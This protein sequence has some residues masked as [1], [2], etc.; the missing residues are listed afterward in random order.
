MDPATGIALASSAIKIGSSIFGNRSKK[1]AAK[2]NYKYQLALQK[3][4]Q[5]W[6]TEMSNTAHQREV[7]DLKAAGLNP[8]LSAGGSGADTGTPGG[9]TTQNADV[10]SPEM[11]ILDAVS[12]AKSIETMDKN[13]EQIDANIRNQTEQTY[14]DTELKKAETAKAMADAGLS[15]KQ[16]EYYLKH[17]VFPGATRT[18][19]MSW[20]GPGGIGGSESTTTPIGYMD[21]PSDPSSAKALERMS[22]EKWKSLS[23]AQ[24]KMFPKDIR[25]LYDRTYN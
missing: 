5:E 21:K 22:K 10:S 6:Q 15:N 4:N 25:E 12:S 1:N 7:A 9:G 14:A 23:W 13:I 18:H 17:G 24:K 19:S 11:N 8:V 3:Q 20:S 16:I 2:Q